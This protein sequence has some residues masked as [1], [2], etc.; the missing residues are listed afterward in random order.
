M[1][2]NAH[3]IRITLGCSA[4]RWML[5]PAVAMSTLQ[6]PARTGY[7]RALSVFGVGGQEMADIA[8]HDEHEISKQAGADTVRRS[9]SRLCCTSCLASS[10][11]SF[12]ACT[13]PRRAPPR[14]P[15]SRSRTP[16]PT[17]CPPRLT[18]AP[19]RPPTFPSPLSRPSRG[20]SSCTSSATGERG[21]SPVSSTRC[22]SIAAHAGITRRHHGRGLG[23]PAMPALPLPVHAVHAGN[24]RAICTS[25]AMLTSRLPVPRLGDVVQP[26]DP[27]LAQQVGPASRRVVSPEPRRGHE[28]RR[29]KRRNV[30]PRSAQASR[31]ARSPPT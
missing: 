12:R 21:C 19:S 1:A 6:T 23:R 30:A 10:S 29:R 13:H 20:A 14:A 15:S 9:T 2:L 7:R 31:P 5:R 27:P 8:S 17:S 3:R 28:V 25:H 16:S 22:V 4:L 26:Q 24:G 11:R 18:R